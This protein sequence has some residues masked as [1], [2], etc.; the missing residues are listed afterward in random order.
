V[1][2]LTRDNHLVSVG[3]VRKGLSASDLIAERL[4]TILV[5]PAVILLFAWVVAQ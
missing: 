1:T 3:A 5:V 4:A 2:R